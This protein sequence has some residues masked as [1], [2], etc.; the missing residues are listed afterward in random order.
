MLGDGEVLKAHVRT[1]RVPAVE[2][3][4]WS[5]GLDEVWRWPYDPQ[6]RDFR[7]T[8][9]PLGRFRRKDYPHQRS[10]NLHPNEEERRR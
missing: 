10:F 7:G 8:V 9:F 5:Q 6:D 1:S 3:S 2:P 4:C